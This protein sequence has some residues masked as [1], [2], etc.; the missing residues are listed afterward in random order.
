MTYNSALTMDLSAFT[1]HV[2]EQ[3][4]ADLQ[5]KYFITHNSNLRNQIVNIL[6]FYKEELKSRRAAAQKKLEE[7]HNNLD[8]LINVN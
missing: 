5:R 1:D 4:I 7:T 6:D 3:K 2:L 8:S